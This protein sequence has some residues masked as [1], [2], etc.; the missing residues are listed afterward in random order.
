[1]GAEHCLP[2]AAEMGS[3]FSVELLN[4]IIFFRN[5]WIKCLAQ[6]FCPRE[7]QIWIQMEALHQEQ[8][9]CT[10]RSGSVSDQADMSF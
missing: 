1:M 7:V 3:I 6:E 8:M 9:S 10:V 4:P 2:Y 5:L